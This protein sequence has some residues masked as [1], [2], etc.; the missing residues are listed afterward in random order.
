MSVLKAARARVRAIFLRKAADADL[1]EEIRFHL[2]L[3]TEKNV[4]LGMSRD[5]AAR[6][7]RARFGGVE[8]AREAHRDVRRLRWL[9]DF[10]TDARFALR[11]MRRTPGLALSAALTL[12]LGIGANVAIFSAVNAVVLQP[13]PFPKAD[14][15]VVIGEDN[16]EKHWRMQLAAP[17]N[18][19]DWRD[20]VSDF[21]DVMGYV[22]ATLQTTLSGEDAPQVLNASMVTG[23]FFSTLGARAAL[24]RTFT[25]DE[26]WRSATRTVILSDRAW[27]Q[28]F[29]GDTSIVGRT[30]TLDRQPALVVGIMPASFGFPFENVD[31]WRT[32][33]WRRESVGTDG[34]RRPH[35]L[36][37][38]AR[39]K[40]GATEAHANAQLQAVVD[41]LKHDYP[42]TNRYMGA[43][44]QSLHGFLVGDTRVPLLVLLSSVA[45]LLLIA[46]ANVGNLLLVQAMGRQ[47]ETALRLAIGAERSRLLRQAMN[48][49]LVLSILGG[50]LGLALG[51]IGTRAFVKLQPEGMLRVASF[52]I[53]HV[54]LLYV[55]GISVAAGVLFGIAPALWYARRDPS[56]SLNAGGRGV[57]S[58]RGGARRSSSV[59]IVVE[60]ALA[61]LL[62]V[63]AGLLVRSFIHIISVDPGFNG[64]GV[65]VAEVAYPQTGDSASAAEMFLRELERRT[66]AL[67]GVTSVAVASSAPYE[68]T[69]F[70]SDFIAFG[71]AP[72]EYGTEI[73]NRT[74]T[75]NYFA[76]MHVP[77]RRGRLFTEEDRVGTPPVVIINETLANSYFRGQDPIGQRIT[78]DK[79]PTP[80]STWYT[81]IG[82]VGDERV[83]GLDSRPIIEEFRSSRQ[84]LQSGGTF[85]VR[86][87]G[88]PAAL[89]APF[90]RLVRELQPNL[91][92]LRTLT[93]DDLRRRSLARARFLATLLIT[94]AIV[95]LALSVVGVYGV[96]AHTARNRTREMGIRIAL[97][98]PTSQVRWLV[99]RQGLALT[100]IGLVVGAA[101]TSVATRYMGSMLF[102][103]VPNDPLTFASVG[104][105]LALTSVIAAWLPAARASRADPVSALRDG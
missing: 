11:T 7:A 101:V 23:N 70:T 105:L 83:N 81:I 48:E 14:R 95:G 25:D 17:A 49:S 75:P 32:V 74:V 4:R 3:E 98:A 27:H 87:T 79:V 13:L 8:S 102:D 12:A 78:F 24:G 50:A 85:L 10:V 28:Y 103:V 59:L 93:M 9:E 22:N 76:T 45:V 67:P 1:Q 21:A 73:G 89:A 37:A 80:Q 38:V 57:V 16:P 5:E 61:L 82:V 62:S 84:Q 26:S 55:V 20:G 42:A 86:T 52:G 97:G 72:G 51:W 63:G 68:G 33:G 77:L 60:V 18:M 56:S 39:L 46:C 66:A 15:L 53:D 2:E 99:V 30:V 36:R 88:D 31:V 54:V 40:D 43:S 71:R 94:F 41:R 34:F 29:R 65:F 58:G 69:S 64:D 19:L 91:A 35:W 96:L 44:M 100:A 92:P 104:A 47:R 90:R 6:V